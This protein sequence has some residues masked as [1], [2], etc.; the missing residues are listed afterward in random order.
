MLRFL[1]FLLG[2]AVLVVPFGPASAQDTTRGDHADA[3][4][5]AR[6]VTEQWLELTDAGDFGESW[7]E[8]AALMQ[9]Q[10]PRETWVEQGKEAKDELE[11]LRS[12]QF[13]RAQYRDSLQQAPSEGPFV[14][15]TYRS[16]FEAGSFEEAVLA[17]KEGDQWKVAGYQV[18]PYRQS[19]PGDDGA[20]DESPDP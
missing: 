6:E 5:A 1:P 19:A 15:L 13:S 14:L 11:A 20:Q 7:D 18:S 17:I 3:K 9:N 16:E 4:E 12:R 8:G 2:V 10:I